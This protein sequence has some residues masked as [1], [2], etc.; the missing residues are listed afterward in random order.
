MRVVLFGAGGNGRE[1]MPILVENLLNE[2][3]CGLENFQYIETNPKNELIHSIAVITEKDFFQ[4]DLSNEILFNV[5]ISDPK[6]RLI[7]VNKFL[8]FGCEPVK[9]ISKDA[10][11]SINAKLG[12]GVTISPFALI[13]PDV[14]IGNFSQINY[15][16]SVSHDVN[17]GNF[18]TIGPGVRINGYIN[19]EDDVFIGAQATIK[20][21]SI[22]NPTVIGKGSKIG[23]GA[24][25]LGD[26]QPNSTVVGNPARKLQ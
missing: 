20:P 17:V 4:Q 16:A 8:S 11:V 1:L 13:S 9:I 21:G 23:M 2:L 25:V 26:V 3:N 12:L 15:F 19:I 24:V 6:T 7:L 18:V 14:T 22:G 5:S 10:K